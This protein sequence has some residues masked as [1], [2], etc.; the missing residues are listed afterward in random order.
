METQSTSQLIH[1]FVR[2]PS[3]KV[4]LTIRKFREKFYL[5]CRIWFQTKEDPDFRPTKKGLSFDLGLLP[6][7]RQGIERLWRVREKFGITRG[8]VP[9]ESLYTP[10]AAQ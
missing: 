9:E 1:S 7:F 5:D 6:E 2:S 8:D 4:F 10:K 3:E